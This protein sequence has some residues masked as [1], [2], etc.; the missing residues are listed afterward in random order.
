MIQWLPHLN[1]SLNSLA[2]VLLVIGYVLVKRGHHQAHKRVMLATFGVSVV[3]LISY[4]TYHANVP[5][6]PF[7]TDTNVA[8]LAVRYIY[9]GILLSHVLL[10]ALVP[11][12]AIASI[13][14]GWR[15]RRDAHR[16]LS[17]WTWPI[18]LFVSVTGVIVYLMLYQ[19]YVPPAGAG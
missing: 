3:F 18:W 13:Y 15:D 7:P 19:I 10:A 12:L 1:V 2:A 9:Y 17:R 4:L 11:F 5:S 8:P 6:K 14:L 16:R